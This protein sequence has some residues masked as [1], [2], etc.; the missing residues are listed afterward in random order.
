MVD[1]VTMVDLAVVQYTVQLIQDLKMMEV[2]EMF[3]L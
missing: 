3:Q 2:V 1:M